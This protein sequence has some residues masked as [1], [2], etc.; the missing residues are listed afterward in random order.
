[1]TSKFDKQLEATWKSLI[2]E[3]DDPDDEVSEREAEAIAMKQKNKGRL[4]RGWE[5]MTGSP[6]EEITDLYDELQDAKKTNLIPRLQ[7]RIDRYRNMPPVIKSP[8][9]EA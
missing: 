4:R 6:D 8:S 3:E 7:A 1:M 9:P 2:V 5:T